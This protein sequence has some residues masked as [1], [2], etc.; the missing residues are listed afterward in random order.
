MSDIKDTIPAFLQEKLSSEYGEEAERIKAG[1][2]AR[3]PVT[4]RANALKTSAAAVGEMLKERGIAYRRLS[5]YEDAFVLEGISEG[6]L[7]ELSAYGRGEI[8]LQSLSSM[9]PP[10]LMKL[11][12]GETILDMTAA[13]GG[14]TA[15]MAAL[16]DGK[17]LITACERDAIRFER[18]K[19]NLQRQGALRVNAMKVDASKLDDFFRF[20][21]ILLDAPCSGSGTISLGEPLRINEKLLLGCMKSQRALLKKAVKLLKKGGILVYSTCSVLKEENE[22]QLKEV[23]SQCSLVPIEDAFVKELPLLN[24]ES[25]TITVC[26]NELFEGFFLAVLRKN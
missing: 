25:G 17:A 13:P 12:A 15:Q 26:P 24:G 2:A 6:E 20:D 4:L 22:W 1:Y 14:K 21:K 7:Q 10:L 19:F 9:L 23:L 16:S 11:K 8:Y 5:W 3:R 18:L